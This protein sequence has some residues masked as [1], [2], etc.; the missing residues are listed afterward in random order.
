MDISQLITHGRTLISAIN[1]A[2]KVLSVI[3]NRKTEYFR[4]SYFHIHLKNLLSNIDMTL[5]LGR[6]DH[7][8]N[9]MR[10]CRVFS[11]SISS[12]RPLDF[13]PQLSAF[14]SFKNNELYSSLLAVKDSFE[15]I[16]S[17]FNY[18]I[19]NRSLNSLI[20]SYYVAILNLQ[21]QCKILLQL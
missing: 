13:L 16:Q 15:F 14:E 2:V 9:I 4:K 1:T 5:M 3:I 10:A 20:E 8:R 6:K 7:P 11:T 17:D 12:E 21:S 18:G 19:A